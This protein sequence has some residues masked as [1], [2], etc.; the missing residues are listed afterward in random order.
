MRARKNF[1]HQI[2]HGKVFLFKELCD[3]EKYLNNPNKIILNNPT[4][5]SNTETL[6]LNSLESL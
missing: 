4:Y 5:D 6:M 1:V 2:A 3:R